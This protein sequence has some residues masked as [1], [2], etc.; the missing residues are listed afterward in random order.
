LGSNDNQVTHQ[1]VTYYLSENLP[2]LKSHMLKCPRCAGVGR[3]YGRDCRECKGRG[4]LYRPLKDER[5]ENAGGVIADGEGETDD[6][7]KAP[8][9]AR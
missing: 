7:L 9:S 4:L 2:P 5:A 6:Q 8:S 3:M 1:G